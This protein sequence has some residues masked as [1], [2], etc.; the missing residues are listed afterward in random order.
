MT[1]GQVAARAGVNVQTLRYY[2]RRGILPE[3]ARTR[4]GYRAYADDSVATVRFVKAAQELGFSLGDIEQL[5]GLARGEPGSCKA[6]RALAGERIAQLE[7]KIAVLRAMRR[8]L[9]RLVK[10]CDRLPSRRVCP[11]LQ[12][13]QGG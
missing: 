3:P 10:T 1:I 9:V 4:S 6:V 7:G 13:V 8:S 11:M 5:L 2:E 12:A